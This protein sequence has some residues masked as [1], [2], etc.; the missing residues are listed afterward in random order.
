M[1]DMGKRYTADLAKE[2]K[3]ELQ[4][5]LRGV[6]YRLEEEYILKPVLEEFPKRKSCPCRNP[7][8][9]KTVPSMK[10]TGRF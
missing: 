8:G 9:L 3:Y 5:Q 1:E 4:F 10:I 7:S 2:L 6:L